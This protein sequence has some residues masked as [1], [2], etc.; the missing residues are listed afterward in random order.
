[1]WGVEKTRWERWLAQNEMDAEV[2]GETM[3][4]AY[5]TQKEVK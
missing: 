3:I 2:E 4:Q 1:M 5:E